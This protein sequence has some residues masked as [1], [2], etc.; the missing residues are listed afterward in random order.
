VLLGTTTIERSLNL[1]AARHMAALDTIINPARMRQIAGRVARIGSR[2]PTV[3][4]HTVLAR[5][6]QEA[7]YPGILQREQALADWLWSEQSDLFPAL[8]PMALLRMISGDSAVRA[9]AGV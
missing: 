4:F 9:A 8:S 3:Y 5:D 2:Q 1:Q 7:A 6:T